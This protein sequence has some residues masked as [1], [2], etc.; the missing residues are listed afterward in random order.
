MKYELSEKGHTL[1]F[2]HNILA[3]LY[4]V[5]GIVLLM[6][7]TELTRLFCI[8]LGI[9]ALLYGGI[10]LLSYLRRRDA[11]SAFQTDLI[12]GVVLL[13]I[14]VVS[15]VQPKIIL[16]ILPLILGIIILLDAIG[17]LQR[18]FR[19]R[20]LFFE[21][22]WIALILAAILALLGITLISNPFETTILFVRFLGFTLVA[23]GCFDLWGNYQYQKHM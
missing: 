17:I 16:S 13:V 11:E 19:L 20:K 18:S 2:S 7:P 21:R 15:L 6:K 8:F 12:L 22:W 4:V 3:F 1:H 9:A 14:G 23:D 5:L 10:R